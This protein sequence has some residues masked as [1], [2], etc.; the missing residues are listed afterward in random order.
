MLSINDIL[1]E[2]R[3]RWLLPALFLGIGMLAAIDIVA[4][5]LEGT[6]F[7]HVLLEVL[8]FT[9]AISAAVITVLQLVREARYT[10][11]QLLDMQRQIACHQQEASDWQQENRDL[12][13]GLGASINRQFERWTLSDA[14]KEVALFLLKGL[15]HKEI[16]LLREVSQSTARQQAR[17]VYQ[18]ANVSGRNELAAFFLEDLALPVDEHAGE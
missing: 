10:R 17:S 18:K 7:A 1:L 12:L 4:D 14:E 15:S 16:S 11:M 8:V 9:I 6:D 2:S 3:F 13:Q 5:I